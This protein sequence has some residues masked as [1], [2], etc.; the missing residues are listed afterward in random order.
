MSKGGTVFITTL[1]PTV[2][3]QTLSVGSLQKGTLLTG[4]VITGTSNTSTEP[5]VSAF[6][7]DPNANISNIQVIGNATC[8][9][10]S[11]KFKNIN[12]NTSFNVRFP[13]DFVY[14]CLPVVITSAADSGSG[15][16]VAN[17]A[18]ITSYQIPLVNTICMQITF[19][20]PVVNTTL[21][22]ATFNYAVFGTTL[23]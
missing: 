20:N 4:A 1:L 21:Q 19:P 3:T 18:F 5:D 7:P 6:P 9:Q 11:F 14:Q 22:T 17:G 23:P 16:L 15:Q 10:V 2:E 12:Q 8:G 13:S